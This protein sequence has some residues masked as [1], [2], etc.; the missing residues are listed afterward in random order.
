VSVLEICRGLPGS[1]K[2]HY[3]LGVLA[4]W[5]RGSIARVS[6]DTIRGQ[7]F[8]TRYEP[9]SQEFEDSVTALQHEMIADLLRRGINVIC[10]DT[11]LYDEHLKGLVNVART[12]DAGW[13]IRSEFTTVPLTTCIHRDWMRPPGQRVGAKTITAMFEKHLADHYPAPLPLPEGC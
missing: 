8:Y 6:R 10:D 9:E 12:V 4:R 2:T 1:G 5:P 13:A 3:A 11:N 7:V